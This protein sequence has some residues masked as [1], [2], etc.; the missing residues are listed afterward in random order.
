MAALAD[1]VQRAKVEGGTEGRQGALGPCTGFDVVRQAWFTA[2]LIPHKPFL[3]PDQNILMK[4]TESATGDEMDSLEAHPGR[5]LTF[6]SGK[7][8]R[9]TQ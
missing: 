2:D 5:D 8:K 7:V 6:R 3:V 9:S 4:V 1:P